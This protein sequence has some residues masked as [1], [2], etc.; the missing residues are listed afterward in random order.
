MNSL[1]DLP[2]L[3][4]GKFSQIE[5]LVLHLDLARATQVEFIIRLDRYCRQQSD[6]H[7]HK[8]PG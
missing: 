7:Q 3:R 6:S 1:N 8:Q 2:L 5:R 4:G